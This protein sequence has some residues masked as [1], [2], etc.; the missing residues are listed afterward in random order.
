MA[1][2]KCVRQ[3]AGNLLQRLK[4]NYFW[5]H[6]KPVHEKDIFGICDDS[7]VYFSCSAG[8]EGL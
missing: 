6:I 1:S 8:A 3:Q 7:S 4:N 5:G 2:D